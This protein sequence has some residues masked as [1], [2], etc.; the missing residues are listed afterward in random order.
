MESLT[1]TVKSRVIS[2][3]YVNFEF[4]KFGRKT[5]ENLG[6]CQERK[7]LRNIVILKSCESFEPFVRSD[8]NFRYPSRVHCDWSV[9]VAIPPCGH[10]MVFSSSP[11]LSLIFPTIPQEEVQCQTSL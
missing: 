5:G 3:R 8:P 11:H 9:V 7:L 4:P 1:R 6:G 10:D 2:K